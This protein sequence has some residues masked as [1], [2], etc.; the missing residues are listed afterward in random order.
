MFLYFPDD[1]D[2]N[3]DEDNDDDEECTINDDDDD[4]DDDDGT[5]HDKFSHTDASKEDDCKHSDDYPRDEKACFLLMMML[6]KMMV[7]REK[8]T[9]I[10]ITFLMATMFRMLTM[11]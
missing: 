9:I 2:D 8:I 5:C 3:Y 1:D 11:I 7:P 10:I 4:D 6:I